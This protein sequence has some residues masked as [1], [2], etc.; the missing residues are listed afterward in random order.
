LDL[1]PRLRCERFSNSIDPTTIPKTNKEIKH[2]LECL[3]KDALSY[4]N[5]IKHSDSFVS[6]FQESILPR[7]EQK[8][9]SK[10]FVDKIDKYASAE[11]IKT[12]FVA[13]SFGKILEKTRE[14]IEWWMERYSKEAKLRRGAPETFELNDLI[15]TTKIAYE[16]FVHLSVLLSQM[17]FALEFSCK[18]LCGFGCYRFALKVSKAEVIQHKEVW[19]QLKRLGQKTGYDCEACA[20]KES[21][22]FKIDFL[23][24]ARVYA[25]TMKV[26]QIT[27]Y[28]TRLA[29][30][31][32]FK[33]GLFKP[34][35]AYFS[36][37]TKIVESNFFLGKKCLPDEYLSRVPVRFLLFAEKRRKLY[38]PFSWDEVELKQL[39]A[40]QPKDALA[41]YLLGR[42]YFKRNDIF[43][44]IECLEKTRRINPKNP[45]AWHLLGILHDVSA[46]TLRD[47]RKA[48]KYL[49]KAR[50]LNPDDV[51]ILFGV[52]VMHMGLG[53]CSQAVEYLER[54][55]K[56]A[57]MP[58]NLCAINQALYEAYSRLDNLTKANNCL[59]TAKETDAS[60]QKRLKEWLEGFLKERKRFQRYSKPS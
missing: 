28:T 32:I 14:D 29:S 11:L 40:K 35:L 42:L 36:Y 16:D 8:K 4:L 12:T 49:E 56:I 43:Q 53:N 58:A 18:M 1:V 51:D 54:A 48:L 57:T 44:A 45:E 24:L 39:T 46:R 6:H 5:S 52:S 23:A 26:R 59:E 38:A 21:C 33:S 3:T 19:R 22:D 60:F 27:D 15:D 2:L 37:L 34:P 10:K 9:L 30:L 31:N 13:S 41:W 20:V 50:E 55:K 47:E 25:Y 7:L 17:F